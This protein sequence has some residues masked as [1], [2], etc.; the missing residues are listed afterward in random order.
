M[1]F[2]I[3][4]IIGVA[5]IGIVTG[6]WT[7]SRAAG[8]TITAC[9]EKDGDLYIIGDG[10][11]RTECKKNDTLFSWN[12]V[13]PQGPKGDKGDSGEQGV[14]GQKGEPGSSSIMVT[15]ADGQELGIYLQSHGEEYRIFLPSIKRYVALNIKTGYG[16]EF[17]H[18][19][20][21]PVFSETNCNGNA[22]IRKDHAPYDLNTLID[23]GNSPINNPSVNHKFFQVSS[24][25]SL[26]T[27]I[28][29]E[30]RRGS[31]F[32]YETFTDVY[33][34]SEVILP[35][36]LPVPAPLRLDI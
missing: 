14:Q 31:C 36:L 9:V 27:A 34:A 29:S 7:Y 35:F 3:V 15:N 2:H 8:N 24:L 22:F 25:T 21:G 11:K 32:N 19:E 5:S 6:F 30:M 4:I 23:A 1:K 10:F 33:P 16:G 12:I 17:N 18:F 28:N 13:G 26:Q 20:N